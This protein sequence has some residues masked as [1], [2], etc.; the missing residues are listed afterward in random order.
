M[1]KTHEPVLLDEVVAY[2]DPE[3]I[4][5][6]KKNICF[7]D[8]TVGFAGHAK[9]F[10]KKRV[11]VLGIDT[12][13]STLKE[14]EKVLEEAC[15]SHHDTMVGPLFKLTHGNFKDIAEIVKRENIQN[16]YGILID[17]GVSTPQLTSDTRGLSFQNREAELDMR[18]D[19]KTSQVRGLELLNAL[20]E[21]QLHDLFDA[22]MEYRD[23]RSL[24]T[25]IVRKRNQ[26]PFKTVGDFLEVIES[27]RQRNKWDRNTK[28]I[29]PATLPFMALRMAVNSELENIKEALPGAFSVL[30]KNGRLAVI[31]F[32]SGED[33]IVKDFMRQKETDGF[34]TILT[35][36]P[37][38]PTDSELQ[39]NPRARSA[40]LRVLEKM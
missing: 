9:E 21:S 37:I 24:V 20:N 4:A 40:K 34:G 36:K 33:A 2:L 31:S 12:D 22:V 30:E 19:T 27:V 25:M 15:P 18:L 29:H 32:H 11:F 39:R 35:K 17:L 16:V 6:S 10:V 28:S 5:H 26:T 38:V 23:T 8:A 14:A 13:E 7:I 1:Q 3:K